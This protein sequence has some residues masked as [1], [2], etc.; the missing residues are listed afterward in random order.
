MLRYIIPIT[1]LNGGSIWKNKTSKSLRKLY[2]FI[3]SIIHKGLNKYYL[4]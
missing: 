1:A 3:L 2:L 4:I